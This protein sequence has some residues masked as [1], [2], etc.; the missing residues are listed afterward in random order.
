MSNAIDILLHEPS[1][2]RVVSVEV[3]YGTTSTVYTTEKKNYNSFT[4]PSIAVKVTKQADLTGGLKDNMLNTGN[5][6]I[7]VKGSL[8][9]IGTQVKPNQSRMSK[10]NL[11]D[12]YIH[13]DQYEALLHGALLMQP[14]DEIEYLALGLPINRM[15]LKDELLKKV[16]NLSFIDR[17]FVIKNIWIASQPFAGLLYHVKKVSGSDG[18]T[19]LKGKTFLT[20]DLGFLTADYLVTDFLTP[21]DDLSGADDLG[22][23]VLIREITSYLGSTEGLNVGDFNSEIVNDA[24]IN[25]KITFFGNQY[26]FPTHK[27]KFNCQP[28]IDRHMRVIVDGIL[29]VVG[30]GHQLSGIVLCGGAS[31]FLLQTVIRAYPHLDVYQYGVD[32]VGKGLQY[33]A[34]LK[35]LKQQRS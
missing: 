32:A 24:F 5:V 19:Y 29:N 16:K 21:N 23:S 34:L 10:R 9:K 35:N 27:G 17:K 22:M 12:S 25:R 7:N 33:G 15:N 26:D 2:N 14:H 1:I 11:N 3:G 18:L 13:S 4:F 30:K 6:E 28:I 20:I 31:E 8:Y